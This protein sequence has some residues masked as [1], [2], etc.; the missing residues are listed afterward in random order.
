MSGNLGWRNTIL[1]TENSIERAMISVSTKN[2]DLGHIH[3]TSLQKNSGLLQAVTVHIIAERETISSFDV[4]AQ[5]SAIDIEQ[6]C[7]IL[8]RKL[9]ITIN[10][11]LLHQTN[12]FRRPFGSLDQKRR[13]FF[14]P[15]CSSSTTN[16]SC[17]RA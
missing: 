7:Q 5:I 6:L 15:N 11:L 17:S 16:S 9:I 14:P 3:L 2:S 13:L 10:M 1:T 4:R 8:S 12:Q